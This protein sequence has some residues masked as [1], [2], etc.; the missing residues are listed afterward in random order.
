[1]KIQSKQ[2]LKDLA[3]KDIPSPDGVFTIGKALANILADAKE[4]GK[5]KLFILATKFFNE[6]DVEV[7]VSDLNLIKQAVK[8]TSMY[9]N[10]VN[11]QLE[12]FLEEIKED[13]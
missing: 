10:L 3:G 6:E 11:G 12:I 4:G 9:N 2:P 13:K 7:D 1:M 5:A 8:N